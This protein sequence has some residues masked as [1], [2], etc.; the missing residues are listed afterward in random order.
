MSRKVLLHSLNAHKYHQKATLLS[1]CIKAFCP[2]NMP[3]IIP[4][5]ITNPEDIREIIRSLPLDPTKLSD[6]AF[7]QMGLAPADYPTYPLQ[8]RLRYKLWSREAIFALLAEA[9][10][11]EDDTIKGNKPKNTARIITFRDR[12]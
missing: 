10:I 6:T 12:E 4:G 2:D 1:N 8:A 7:E 5:G 3:A 9:R 11:F